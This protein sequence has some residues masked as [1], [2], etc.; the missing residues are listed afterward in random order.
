MYALDIGALPDR[1]LEKSIAEWCSQFGPVD[2]VKTLHRTVGRTYAIAR[3]KM[4][5][6]VDLQKVLLCIGESSAEV[7][8]LIIL[9]Q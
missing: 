2:S 7:E 8:A 5:A 4:S 6:E 9:D 3:V 1:E